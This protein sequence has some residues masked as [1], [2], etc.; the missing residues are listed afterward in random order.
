M[1]F[2]DD[3][4]TRLGSNFFMYS[5]DSPFIVFIVAPLSSRHYDVSTDWVF[6]NARGRQFVGFTVFSSNRVISDPN[7][8]Q[9]IACG[10]TE[11]GKKDR[12]VHCDIVRYA[13]WRTTRLIVLLW[14]TW[15]YVPV[16]ITKCVSIR[17]SNTP[18]GIWRDNSICRINDLW[19]KF[20]VLA[21]RVFYTSRSTDRTWIFYHGGHTLLS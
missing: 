7:Q 2:D 20:G 15:V 4:R 9:C 5:F 11:Y 8:Y 18:L 12:R 14:H 13:Q 3:D 10:I 19:Y 6:R 21:A 17:I 16:H 1:G